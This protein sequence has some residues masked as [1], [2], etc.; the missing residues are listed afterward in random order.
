[1]RFMITPSPTLLAT[2]GNAAHVTTGPKM[3]DLLYD[4]FYALF[5]LKNRS[6]PQSAKE[7][8]SRMGA[9]LTDFERQAQKM[10]RS[11]EEISDAKFAFCATAD[12][13]ILQP[14][15]SIRDE[16]ERHP[17][18]LTLFGTLLAGKF[19]FTKLE[20][21]RSKGSAHVQVL[22]VFYMCLLMG[23]QGKYMIEGPEKLNYLTAQLGEQ[24]A[25][26]KNKRA[27]FAP[28]WARP[29]EI[30][31]HIKSEA[32]LWVVGGLFALLAL[33]AF[34]ALNGWL[35]R[36]ASQMLAGYPDEAIT[37]APRAANITITLP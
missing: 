28:H 24:I 12:E 21:W 16:W 11:S 37:L 17:L 15:F 5:L 10:G 6:V 30:R 36:S 18:Q 23:F 3:A 35:T 4:G 25:Q 14:K 13:I 32:P 20:E 33:L 1:M 27:P 34:M 22:E 8:A 29:D 31:H 2:P 26:M 9:F 19:F 7:L